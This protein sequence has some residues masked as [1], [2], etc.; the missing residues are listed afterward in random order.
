[1]IGDFVIRR[2]DGG[3]AFFFTNALDDALMGVTEVLRAEDHLSNTPRQVLLLRALD[4]PVPRYGHVSLIVDARGAP[5]SKRAGSASLADLRARGYLPRAVV[6][7]LAR[8]GHHYAEGECL[9]LAGLAAGFDPAALGSAPAR[10][11]EAQLQHW[12]HAALAVEDGEALWSWLGE[13]TRGQVPGA[14]GGAFIDAIRGNVRFPAE[15]AAWAGRLFG[16]DPRPDAAAIAEVRD[17]GAAF[18]QA[19]LGALDAG[20]QDLAALVT[21]LRA[22]TGRSG[23]ALFRPLRAALTGTL[24]GPELARVFSLLGAG[25]VRER[26][27]AAAAIAAGAAES[28][29]PE[30]GRS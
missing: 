6:N 29:H 26:L 15:A 23:K 17:G 16:P 30:D 8:L 19:A 5:L 11:E 28:L 22:R 14:L 21:V 4:L 1:V 2:A 13:E 20:A 10:F 27:A 12:Q 18:F 24:E 3:P 7:Y 9:D 25:R